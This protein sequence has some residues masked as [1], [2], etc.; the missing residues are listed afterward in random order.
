MPP[1]KQR[2]RRSTA[3]RS[4]PARG[5]MWPW[6][7]LA[8]TIVAAIVAR[9][10]LDDLTGWLRPGNTIRSGTQPAAARPKPPEPPRNVRQRTEASAERRPPPALAEAPTPGPRPPGTI[11]GATSEAPPAVV[12]GTAPGAGDEAAFFYCGIKQDNCVV[13]GA[14]FIYRGARIR[15]ADIYVPA[16]K[17][18]KCDRERNLGGDAKEALRILLNAGDFELAD[19]KPIDEDQHGR[20]LRV[21][22]RHGKSIGDAMVARGLAR[23]WTGQRLSWCP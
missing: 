5:R 12:P 18:A 19:W 14:N 23:P 2:K 15:L 8:A 10:N 11:P 4:P 22:V 17:D 6:Y 13:D 7:L 21:V 16:T 1:K 3:R 9:E 20:K